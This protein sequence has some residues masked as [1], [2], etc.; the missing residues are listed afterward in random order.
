MPQ[1]LSQKLLKRAVVKTI[2]RR[3]LAFVTLAGLIYGFSALVYATK[4]IYKVKKNYAVVIER[5][6]GKREVVTQ[7]GWHIRLPYFTKIEQ[8]MALMNQTLFL[9]GRNEP[10]A[11]HFSG[12]RG[13]LDVGPFDLPDSRPGGLGH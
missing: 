1:E 7:I 2:L 10:H 12:K 5:F 11:D 13:P 4:T 6:G 3:I 9:G 8:E